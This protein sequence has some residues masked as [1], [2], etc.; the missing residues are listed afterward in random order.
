MS[1]CHYIG[2]FR[3]THYCKA[4]NDP[5][6][7]NITAS[8]EPASRGTCA[9]DYSLYKKYKGMF[10]NLEWKGMYLINDFHRRGKNI[11]DLYNGDYDECECDDCSDNDKVLQGG[12]IED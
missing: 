1:L 9:L 12:I 11:A 6:G 4:C 8:G 7:S 5:P 10:L 3:I 2:K